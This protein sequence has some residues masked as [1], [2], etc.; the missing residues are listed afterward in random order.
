[1]D[2]FSSVPFFIIESNLL[3][4]SESKSIPFLELTKLISA[5]FCALPASYLYL[6]KQHWLLYL[7]L[8]PVQT[9]NN[10]PSE[11]NKENKTPKRRRGLIKYNTM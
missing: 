4:S 3:N 11:E 2:L 5:L 8:Q 10:I 9:Q 7:L 6:V 1:M